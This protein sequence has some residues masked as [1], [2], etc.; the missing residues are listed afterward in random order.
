[1]L[2]AALHQ[3]LVQSVLML[4]LGSYFAILVH[5]TR[6]LWASVIAHAVNNLAVLALM[7]AYGGQIPEFTAPWWMYAMSGLVFSL[8]LA[9]LALERPAARA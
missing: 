6:S 1:M 3:T 8:A 4:C 5:L 2:F 9:L 7:W